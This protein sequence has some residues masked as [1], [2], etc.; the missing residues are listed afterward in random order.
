MR[1]T[2]NRGV[3]HPVDS[4]VNSNASTVA[5]AA[6][7]FIFDYRN[8]VV[9]KRT[10][11]LLTTVLLNGKWTKQAMLDRLLNCLSKSKQSAKWPSLLVDA[12]FEVAN[13]QNAPS[14]RHLQTFLR[15]GITGRLR[16]SVSAMQSWAHNTSVLDLPA[17]AM[18]PTSVATGEWSLPSIVSVHQL[19]GFL[20]VHLS[21][22]DALAD[23]HGRERSA[24]YERF[25]NYR[26]HWIRKSNGQP[27]LLEAPKER[28]KSVQQIIAANILSKI[29]P[30]AAA[31][32]FVR[33]R[34]PLTSAR[35]HA[36]RSM[37]MRI[38][39][40]E[41][42][43]SINA[44]RVAGI[45]R[46]AGY[47]RSVV[48]LLTGL[49]TNTTW[50]GV[51]ATASD[52]VDVVG[53][54]SEQLTP[55]FTPHLPQGA[56]TSPAL[57]NLVAYSL[58][59]RLT[60]LS[61]KFGVTY[62]RYADDL[63]FSGNRAFCLAASR[64]RILAL[65][66]VLN[67][68]FEIRQ[69]KTLVMKSSQQQKVTG[70]VVNNRPTIARQDYDRLKAILTNCQRTGPAQQ[71]REKHPDFRSHLL[72]KIAYFRSINPHRGAKLQAAFDAINWK[73]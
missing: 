36:G 32:A 57:A 41:F 71:N 29:P 14:E 20:K 10:S 47:P 3:K 18:A 11:N 55:N 43:P 45:F 49:C 30:H 19:A 7:D 26:Y 66:I 33:G 60:G 65:A 50:S 21:N 37:V 34:S 59:C 40:R 1:R 28:L 53:R 8:I 69:R 62:T 15:H 42:F 51:A 52:S 12:A 9:D 39:L 46:A 72:G 64:F 67:E 4:R 6:V 38:D 68:G 63:I 22:I 56:P 24:I 70:L 23:V 17:P 58:D 2:A 27:R 54:V 25:R 44:S 73:T 35:L 31:H 13:G 61:Q 48:A 5:V 16:R